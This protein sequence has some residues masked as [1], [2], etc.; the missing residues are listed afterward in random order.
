MADT[1]FSPSWYRVAEL[2]P[3]LRS[4]VEIHRHSYRGEVWFVLQDHATSRSH[5]LHPAAYRFIGLMDGKR[6]VAEIWEVVNAAGQDAAPTQDSVIRLL[7]QLHAADALICNVP[8]DTREIFRRFQR[9]ERQRWRQRLWTPLAIRVP[10]VDPDRFLDRTLFLV[11]PLLGWAGALLWL[12]LVVVGMTLA[13]IHWKAITHNIVDQALT[14]QNLLLLWFVYPA[15]KAV[16]ELGHAYVVKANG[17]EVHE[18]GLMFLVFIP[19]PYVDASAASGFTEKRQRMLVGGIGI[20]VEMALAAIALAVWLNASPGTVH[21]IAYNVM[22]IGGVSTLLFNGNPLLRFDGYYVLADAIEIPNLGA[23]ANAYWGYLARRYLFAGKDATPPSRDRGERAWFVGYGAAAFVYRF[24]VVFLILLY[25]GTK[26]FAVGV[27]LALWAAIT[28]VLTPI[29]KSLR[30]LFASQQLRRNR[31]RAVTTAALITAAFGGLLFIVPL[32][33]WT[34]AEG[35]TWPAENSHVRAAGDGFVQRVLAADGAQVKA[36]DALI[37]L[38]DPF[39]E[40]RRKVLQAQLRGLE[41][42]FLALRNT[43][44]IEA[45]VVQE[46]IA[47]VRSDLERA[48]ERLRSLR[49]ASPRDGTLVIPGA[50]DLP[51]RFVR[52]GQLVGYVIDASDRL[53]AR[54]IVTQDEVDLVRERTRAVQVIASEWEARSATT[55]VVREVPGGVKSLPSAALGALGGGRIAIDPRDGKGVTTFERVF[56]FE[57]ELPESA[58]RAHVGQRASVRFDHGYEPAAFQLYRSI[59][60]VFLRLFN[61]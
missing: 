36:G 51:D 13:G 16:H 32:P 53:T 45:G 48:E 14:P 52:K 3:R 7:G 6:S 25:V 41:L 46:E 31:G 44:R 27:L 57:V 59:R 43:D 5:R 4:H 39:L 35:V 8:P 56:E 24:Y 30:Q 9:Q 33:L 28:Q 21:A 29:G 19:V 61:V 47:V 11:Q 49:V 40:A 20:M 23:R 26:F 17:G 50:S 10:L 15:V 37:E 60:Q 42:Q 54:A 1:I 55:A 18:I 58:V 12:A 2:K 38:A 22:L 34:K